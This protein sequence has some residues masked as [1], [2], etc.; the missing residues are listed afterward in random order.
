MMEKMETYNIESKESCAIL[1]RLLKHWLYQIS[2]DQDEYSNLTLEAIITKIRKFQ[3]KIGYNIYKFYNTPNGINS[4][5]LIRD[6]KILINQK[7]LKSLHSEFSVTINPSGVLNASR[8]ILPK[9]IED[10]LLE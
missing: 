9:L 2:K 6:L 4:S 10:G 3:K 7:N 5:E 8:I 1:L